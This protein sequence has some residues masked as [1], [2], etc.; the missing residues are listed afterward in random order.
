MPVLLVRWPSAWADGELEAALGV[1]NKIRVAAQQPIAIIVDAREA[2]RPNGDERATIAKVMRDGQ[3]AD[4]D[5]VVAF[6]LITESLAATGILLALG[7]LARSRFPMKAFRDRDAAVAW[8]REQLNLRA[9]RA[10]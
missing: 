2:K 6:A 9:L 8:S 1:M 5:S 4:P 7:W 10:L 3:Q